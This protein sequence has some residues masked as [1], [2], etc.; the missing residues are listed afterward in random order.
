MNGR[1]HRRRIS[2]RDF[3]EALRNGNVSRAAIVDY[4][5]DDID[6]NI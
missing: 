5:Y 1:G 4:L 3:Y 2:Q 6:F